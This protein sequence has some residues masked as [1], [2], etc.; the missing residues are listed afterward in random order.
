M[1]GRALNELRDYTSDAAAAA[2]SAHADGKCESCFDDLD[3][4]KEHQDK[5]VSLILP[6][7]SDRISSKQ[8]GMKKKLDAL[9]K[10]VTADELKPG[11]LVMIKDPQYLLNPHVR[12]SSQ[13]EWIGPYTVVRRTLYGPYTLRNDT[14]DVYDRSVPFDQMKVLY[15]PTSIPAERKEDEENTYEVDYIMEHRE[16]NGEYYYKIKWK[17]Y[18]AKDAT[19]ITED[20]FNDPQP[21]ERYFK[22]LAAKQQA[23]RTRV[24]TLMQ[25]SSDN[26]VLNIRRC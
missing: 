16:E 7:I 14:G 22:L 10:K 17:G 11:T 26:I 13:P 8:S 21:V 12:P 9:R 25:S 1:F 5:V 3:A 19:W 20:K 23:K 18:D 2:H 15:S 4:W 6:S 24:S